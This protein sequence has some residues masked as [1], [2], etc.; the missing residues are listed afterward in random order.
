MK[1]KLSSAIRKQEGFSKIGL[2]IT[3]FVL[4]IGLTFGLKVIPIYIDHSFV[5]GIAESL[6]ESGRAAT[7]TQAEVRQEIAASMRVNNI[8]DFDLNSITATR[9][10]GKAAI[11]IKYERRVPLFSNLDV[12]ASFDDRI[13]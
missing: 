13:E 3:L 7:L 2:I 1:N 4:I 8:R 6:V 9:A 11:T 10:S 5:R 12:V